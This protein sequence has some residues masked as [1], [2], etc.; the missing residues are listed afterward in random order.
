MKRALDFTAADD[1]TFWMS[2]EDFFGY[3]KNLD[4][5]CRWVQGGGQAGGP[6]GLGL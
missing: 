1:G 6:S 2:W 5:C 4:F 3:Y